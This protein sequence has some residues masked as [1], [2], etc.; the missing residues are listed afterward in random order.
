MSAKNVKQTTV[1]KKAF[2]LAMQIFEL[3]KKFP[4]EE[5]YSLTDQ[6]RRSSRSVCICLLEA[7]RKKIYPAHFV[8]K[9]T[10]SDMENSE[11]SG[12]LDFSLAC[13]YVTAEQFNEL[14]LQNEEIGKLL[15]HMIN[16]PDKY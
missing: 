6:I 1:Y 7:Y 9:V 3:S 10:D 5:K 14:I 4:S 8:A 2:S 12:W 16:N 11:T 15:Y 13:K